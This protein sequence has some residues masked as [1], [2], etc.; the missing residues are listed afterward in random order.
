[1]SHLTK[2]SEMAA[3]F[4]LHVHKFFH[5]LGERTRSVILDCSA[6]PEV[7]YTVVQV[8]TTGCLNMEYVCMHRF[9]HNLKPVINIC[10]TSLPI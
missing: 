4:M 5:L 2:S 3:V 1:M 7:D 8:C 9:I 10:S 6:M